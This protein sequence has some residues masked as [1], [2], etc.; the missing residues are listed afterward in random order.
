MNFTRRIFVAIPEVISAIIP[1]R[2]SRR[3]L[4]E[5]PEKSPYIQNP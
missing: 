1:K 4:E 2:I 5:I 3:F